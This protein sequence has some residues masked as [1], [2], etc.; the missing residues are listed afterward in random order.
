[1]NYFSHFLVKPN[2][3]QLRDYQTT[4][5]EQALNENTLVILPTGLGKTAIALMVIAQRITGERKCVLVAPTKPLC[6]QH[7]EYF[8][9]HLPYT[10]VRILVTPFAGVWVEMNHG[11]PGYP[12]RHTVT[13]FAGVWVEIRMLS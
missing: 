3:V 11:G 7:Y 4:I 10:S 6:E 5:S 9:K 1:M 12:D 2:T 13:P 8:S